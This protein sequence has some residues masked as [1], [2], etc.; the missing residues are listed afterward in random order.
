MLVTL[1]AIADFGLDGLMDSVRHRNIYHSDFVLDGT[2]YLTWKLNLQ[3]LLDGIRVSDQ[4]DGATLMP[5]ASSL[6][7]SSSSS[8]DEP[9]GPL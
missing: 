7:N 2:N 3:W 5:T 6:P 4:F 8:I 9:E 1:P